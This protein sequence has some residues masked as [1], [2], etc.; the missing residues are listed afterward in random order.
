MNERILN[1][2][3][4]FG[5]NL[6]VFSEAYFCLFIALFALISCSTQNVNVQHS[7]NKLLDEYNNWLN[8]HKKKL[9]EIADMFIALDNKNKIESGMY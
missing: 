2:T 4:E 3:H 6:R 8:L 5:Q 9:A 7:D 1:L